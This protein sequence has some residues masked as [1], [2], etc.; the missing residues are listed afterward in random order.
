MFYDLEWNTNLYSS[1][2]KN[3]MEDFIMHQVHL[4]KILYKYP[5]RVFFFLNQKP[6]HFF[7]NIIMIKCKDL[8]MTFELIRIWIRIPIQVIKHL[9]IGVN[10]ENGVISYP[11]FVD[12]VKS[13]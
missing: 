3:H 5:T 11:Q 8:H 6:G 12:S 1:E 4:C 9:E 10:L 13:V 2:F 7:R